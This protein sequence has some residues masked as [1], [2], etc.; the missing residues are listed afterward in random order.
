[1]KPTVQAWQWQAAARCRGLDVSV[2]FGSDGEERH[3]RSQREAYA[4][5]V[6]AQCPVIDDCRRHAVAAV[7]AFGVWGGQSAAERLHLLG[8][9]A[10]RG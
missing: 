7:E 2:F 3:K 9:V 4:K 5:A 6:C 1:L 8:R 10:V